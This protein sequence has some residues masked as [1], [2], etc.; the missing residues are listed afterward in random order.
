MHRLTRIFGVFVA[1][2]ALVAG[3][4]WWR[5]GRE[6]LRVGRN[7]HGVRLQFERAVERLRMP[8][9]ANVWLGDS[10]LL[11]TRHAPGY[12]D[13]LADQDGVR[14][15]VLAFLGFNFFHYYCML[16]SVLETEPRAVVALANLRM[17][18]PESDLNLGSFVDLCGS[19]PLGEL[20]RALGLPFPRQGVGV[21]KLLSY[22]LLRSP[23]AAQALFAFDGLHRR[24]AERDRTGLFVRDEN[25]TTQLARRTLDRLERQG[26]AAFLATYDV[27]LDAEHPTVQMMAAAV[28]LAR[29]RGVTM[30]VLAAPIPV[31][32]LR[33]RGWYRSENFAVLRRVVEADGGKFVDLHAA[34][35]ADEFRDSSG[36]YTRAG[37][38][39][40]A[41]RVKSGVLPLLVPG[42]SGAPAGG[43]AGS[44]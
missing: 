36:H 21:A 23:V 34:L 6:I 30:V 15:E 35:A 20:P 8:P 32:A 24:L 28:A 9:P 43:S 25:P 10:T 42:E 26:E 2:L 18:N 19:L 40:L 29:E 16:P 7:L 39:A 37:A 33:A 12:T 27:K 31:A 17:F 22:Q 13:L 11:P 41:R 1:T 4:A 3:A 14:Q 44:G 5:D 38:E